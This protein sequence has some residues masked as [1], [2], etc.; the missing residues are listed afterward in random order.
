MQSRR[1]LILTA[2]LLTLVVGGIWHLDKEPRPRPERPAPT[3]SL[4]AAA[5]EGSPSR[6]ESASLAR[7]RRMPD[8][9]SAAGSFDLNELLARARTDPAAAENAVAFVS[10]CSAVLGNE[11][12]GRRAVRFD[13]ARWRPWAERCSRDVLARVMEDMGN[14]AKPQGQDWDTLQDALAP[15][16]TEASPEALA[17]RDALASAILAE[18]S[19]PELVAL[20]AYVYFDDQR[21]RAWALADLPRSLVQP[22]LSEW[23]F[24]LATLLACRVGRDCS[25]TSAVVIAQCAQT[26]GCYPGMSLEDVLALRRSPQDIALMRGYVRQ[27]LAKRDVR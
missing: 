25:P 15:E 3:T 4:N 1:N 7:R 16:S 6:P 21:L 11:Y 17:Q 27:V 18:S 26:A 12:D 5:V 14:W 9:D 19:D 23:R 20:A 22:D 8:R 10:T 24:D 2:T 13:D